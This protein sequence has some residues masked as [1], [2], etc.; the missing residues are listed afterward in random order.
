M[1]YAI[2]LL[3]IATSAFGATADLEV[4]IIAPKTWDADYLFSWSARVTNRGPDAANVHIN[5]AASFVSGT[6]C[7]GP[8][9]LHINPTIS[10]ELTCVSY[11]LHR[12]GVAVLGASVTSDAT[13]PNPFNNSAAA[14]VRWVVGPNLGTGIFPEKVFVDP[15]L[16]FDV[17]A[18]YWNTSAVAATNTVMTIDLPDGATLQSAPDYC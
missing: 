10:M 7:F 3:L 15:G 1:R 6:D 8:R 5:T 12:D 11:T 9:D 13:D 16:P 14:E 4:S 18:Q 2:L 17:T